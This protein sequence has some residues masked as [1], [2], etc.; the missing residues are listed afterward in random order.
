[1]IQKIRTV[2]PRARDH[3]VG[4]S[5]CPSLNVSTMSTLSHARVSHQGTQ[6]SKYLSEHGL[7]RRTD[8]VNIE[9]SSVGQLSQRIGA[10]RMS[11]PHRAIS[12]KETC[13]VSNFAQFD[14]VWSLLLLRF[15]LLSF[16]LVVAGV[17]VVTTLGLI[18][19][20]HLAC[21]PGRPR[22]C[23][24]AYQPVSSAYIGSDSSNTGNEYCLPFSS[25]LTCS[26]IFSRSSGSVGS[27]FDEGIV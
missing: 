20:S 25:D 17:L 9:S 22:A 27:P 4:R 21:L 3:I 10:E 24:S 13:W 15:S 6:Q 1:M 12:D 11:L 5:D 7:L 23:S 18:A 8:L 26:L 19:T 14:L 16:V 2:V